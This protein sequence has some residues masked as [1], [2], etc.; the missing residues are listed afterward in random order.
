MNQPLRIAFL[1]AR[2]PHIFPRLS[3]CLRY[4]D[5]K[6]TGVYDSNPQLSEAIAQ[7]Y[8]VPFARTVDD[9]FMEGNSDL[10]IIEGHDPENPAYLS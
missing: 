6:I 3:L 2:H 4:E 1:G 7:K 9:L 8:D 10:V 5:V